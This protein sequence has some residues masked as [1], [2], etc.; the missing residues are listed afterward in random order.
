MRYQEHRFVSRVTLVGPSRID[1]CR[2]DKSVRWFN[3]ET[4]I[5]MMKSSL[6]LGAT[7]A[8]ALTAMAVTSVQ[9]GGMEKC[10]ASPWPVRTTAPPAQA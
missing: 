10:F 5:M 4:D 2:A 7:L 8:C 1:L 3:M 9:A 6:T